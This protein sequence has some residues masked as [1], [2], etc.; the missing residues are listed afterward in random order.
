MTMIGGELAFDGSSV[1]LSLFMEIL[2]SRSAAN[3][4]HGLHPKVIG[5]NANGAHSL[6]ERE[7]Y[8]EAQSVEPDDGDRIS[9]QVGAEKNTSAT[10]GM[11]NKDKSRE[12][13]NGSPDHVDAK[14][15][16]SHALL[17]IYGTCRLDPLGIGLIEELKQANFSSVYAR[18]SSFS[19][20]GRYNRARFKCD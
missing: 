13:V 14:I 17:T 15:A 7:F 4:V 3:L 10:R 9:G 19:F 2:I 18:P 6:F 12:P 11:I 16:K 20:G 5:V 8:F 1:G